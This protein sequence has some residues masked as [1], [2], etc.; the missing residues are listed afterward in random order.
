M[1][2]IK[3]VNETRQRIQAENEELQ[4]KIRA[5]KRQLKWL[6]KTATKY[7]VI[8]ENELR[9][10]T[11]FVQGSPRWIDEKLK[12]YCE[13]HR[14]RIV[15]VKARRSIDISMFMPPSVEQ[16]AHVTLLSPVPPRR[17]HSL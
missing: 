6:H 10:W 16:A 2:F 8:F 1:S 3:I 5:N 13:H 4:E 11:E 15:G 12:Q 9:Q 14:A 17:S 7:D